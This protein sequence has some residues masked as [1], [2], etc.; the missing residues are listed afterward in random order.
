M[1]TVDKA[2]MMIKAG[3]ADRLNKHGNGAFAGRHEAV[4]IIV[5][6]YAELIDALRRDDDPGGFVMECEGIGVAA[7][8]AMASMM[9]RGQS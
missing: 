1:E 9:Q 5:E 2:L 4:G 7:V 6:E 8:L 3:I